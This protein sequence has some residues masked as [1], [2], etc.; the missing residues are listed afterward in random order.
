[1]TLTAS[2]I[3]AMAAFF[4]V[5]AAVSIREEKR[6]RIERRLSRLIVSEQKVRVPSK[7]E[8]RLKH[9]GIT[10]SVE[11]FYLLALIGGAGLIMALIVNGAPIIVAAAV[12]GVVIATST[13]MVIYRAR[14]RAEKLEGQLEYAILSM[15]AALKVGTIEEAIKV[16]ARDSDDPLKEELHMVIH[17]MDLG[18]S[19]E[20]ALRNLAKRNENDLLDLTVESI[21][22]GKESGAKLSEILEKTARA[23][24]ARAQLKGEIRA[25]S[26]YPRTTAYTIMGIPVVFLLIVWLLNP[27]YLSY[28][29]S[30]T[31]MMALAYAAISISIGSYVMY[32]MTDLTPGIR[33]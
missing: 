12:V 9:A 17:E 23:V 31:G 26:A 27:S 19:V 1:M 2:V 24:Q 6:L 30:E 28:L 11:D 3:I 25:A 15:S 4:V 22:L 8:R 18:E 21:I 7:F 13:I 10:L 16:A 29:S 20:A 33:S 32:K 14:K 5:L